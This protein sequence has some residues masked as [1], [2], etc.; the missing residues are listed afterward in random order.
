MGGSDYLKAYAG[1][2]LAAMATA[3][4]LTVS[5]TSLPAA[6]TY[7]AGTTLA[8]RFHSA[9][10]SSGTGFSL[11]VTFLGKLYYYYIIYFYIK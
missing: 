7:S 11:T 9:V 10:G 4:V 3:P 6:F 2:T 1:N 5:G 8:L